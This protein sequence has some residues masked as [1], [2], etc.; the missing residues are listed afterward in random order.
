M[1]KKMF[2]VIIVADEMLIR[3]RIRLGFD[4]NA[5]GYEVEDDV[6]S[7]GEAPYLIACWA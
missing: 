4:W 1:K 6:G 5:L 3:K 7:G 2:K